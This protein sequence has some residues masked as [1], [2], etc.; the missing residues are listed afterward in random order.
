[1][2]A[3]SDFR[4]KI[5]EKSRIVEKHS[6]LVS[7]C[8]GKSV[9][10]VGCIDHSISV[11]ESLGE[12]WLHSEICDVSKFTIGLDI[13]EE[14]SKILNAKG[15]NIVVGDAENFDLGRKFDVIIA[16]DIIEHLSNIGRFVDCCKRHMNPDSLLVIT[17]PNPFNI[18]QLWKIVFEK[19]VVVNTQ[20][21]V[22]IDPV[23]AYQVLHRH[24]MAVVDFCWIRTRF[25]NKVFGGLFP[26][27]S[28]WIT[29]YCHD[30]H[31]LTR[32]DFAIV[33]QLLV[34]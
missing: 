13:L 16:G 29:A 15:F 14:E 3:I 2:R 17:T 24:G 9:L 33:A 28:N 18:E 8:T 19:Q 30:R 12:K 25:T 26:K 11:S 7:K 4:K 5:S 6:F 20:H 23:V 32:T 34:D 27:I 21:T 1:M 22:W 31:P 10:D